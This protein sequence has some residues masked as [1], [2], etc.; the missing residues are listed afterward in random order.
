M[1]TPI[2]Y[3]KCRILLFRGKGLISTLIR[4]QTRGDYSHAAILLPDGKTVIEAWQGSGVRKKEITNWEGIDTFCI[5]VNLMT[6][7]Q[8]KLAV[9]FAEAEL[10][11]KYDYWAIV[12]FVSR[13]V[14][15]ENDK[16]FCSELVYSCIK[17][18]GLSLFARIEAWAV[19][20]G[21]LNNSPYMYKT[22]SDRSEN[23]LP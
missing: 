23:S 20:P 19:S 15:P 9:T 13:A 22:A 2:D 14:M 11:K 1:S 17:R 18:A 5:P 10:G 8:W 3:T 4:W 21:M 6:A 12:R 16:W 7:D